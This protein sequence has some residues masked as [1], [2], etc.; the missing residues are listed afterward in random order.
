MTLTVYSRL[1]K[2]LVAHG[3]AGNTDSAR[4]LISAGKVMING[5][6]I[7]HPGFPM[8]DSFRLQ[9]VGK[10]FSLPAINRMKLDFIL[11]AFHLQVAGMRIMLVCAPA[12]GYAAA[13][14]AHGAGEIYAP[15]PP[16]TDCGLIFCDLPH[17]SLEK[18]IGSLFARAAVNT[19]LIAAIRPQDELDSETP[20]ADPAQQ[21]LACSRIED[22]LIASGWRIVGFTPNPSEAVDGNREFFVYATKVSMSDAG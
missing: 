18:A 10:D 11:G 19:A 20:V 15:D 12:S 1:D 7:T 16:R 5:Q 14:S 4:N 21:R 6:I 3:Y 2:F 9:I 8:H 13:F 22:W 17:L